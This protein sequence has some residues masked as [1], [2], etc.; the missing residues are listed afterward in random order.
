[1]FFVNLIKSHILELRRKTYPNTMRIFYLS[2]IILLITVQ[3]QSQ[4]KALP[5]SD[6]DAKIVKFY[7]NPAVTT[8]TFDF[9]SNFDKNYS[10]QIFNFLGKK[11]FESPAANPKTIVN[12]SEFS[13]GIYI[14]W[15]RDQSGKILQSGKFQVMK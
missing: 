9:E 1:L 4:S 2:S 5:L 8:I 15:V 13:R 10:F 3:A 7:P 12:V 14:F 11:V 6:L